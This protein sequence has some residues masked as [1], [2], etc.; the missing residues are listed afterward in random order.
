MENSRVWYSLRALPLLQS[1]LCG[2]DKNS[3]TK[4]KLRKEILLHITIPGCGGLNMFGPG[5]WLY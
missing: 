1:H 5:K 4:K 3:L 2:F